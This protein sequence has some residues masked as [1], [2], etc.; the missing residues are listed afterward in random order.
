MSKHAYCPSVEVLFYREDQRLVLRD[1]LDF[2]SPFARDL[3]GCLNRLC[4]SVHGKDH[5]EAEQL[6]GILGKARKHIV[7]E[8]TTTQSQP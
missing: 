1:T 3:D 8:G 4:A 5:V 2:V 7:V 6:G